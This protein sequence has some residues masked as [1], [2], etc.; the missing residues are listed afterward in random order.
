MTMN[1]NNDA[2]NFGDVIS[3]NEIPEYDYIILE[4][5]EY[6][7]VIDAIERGQYAGGDKMGPCPTVKVFMHVDTPNGKAFMNNQLFLSKKT[8]GLL[9]QFFESVGMKEKGQDINLNWF[10]NV[11]GRTARIKTS[12][13]EYNGKQYNQVDRFIATKKNATAQQSNFNGLL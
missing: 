13:R 6:D 11:A 2:L 1:N 5:G 7:C 3:A 4:P 8:L 9:A 10:D 12:V